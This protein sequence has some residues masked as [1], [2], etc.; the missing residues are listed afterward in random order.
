MLFLAILVPSSAIAWLVARR[1]GGW[2]EHARRGL[3]AATV[4]AGITHFTKVDPFVQHLPDWV[5]AREMV[6]YVTGA[7]EIALGA[8]LM[9][10]G[11]HRTT[12]GRLVAAYLIAVFPA[13]VYVA[14]ADVEVSGQPGG[15]Y[16][17]IRLPLQ[18]LFVA[19][20][21]ASTAAGRSQH[22]DRVAETSTLPTHSV[23]S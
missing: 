14:L 13:N 8:A 20:A 16:A 9:F 18:A 11:A 4:I 7:I 17:W 2:R 23:L 22:Q 3:A 21:L 1:S 12:V 5:P 19:W 15:V 6:V 10:A